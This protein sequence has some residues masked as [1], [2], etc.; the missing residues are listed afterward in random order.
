MPFLF[1]RIKRGQPQELL[2]FYKNNLSAKFV[3]GT[4]Y[5]Y[6]D[7]EYILLGLIIEHISKKPLHQFFSSE[8]FTPLNLTSTYLNLK[9]DPLKKT[10]KMMKVMVEDI[11][12]SNF[13]SLSADWAGG[14]IV[15]TNSDLIAFFSWANEW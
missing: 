9:S 13:K 3:P 1:F 7:T 6:T 8:I 5:H 14:G 2:Q 15:S 12:I 11:D 10:G 4:S